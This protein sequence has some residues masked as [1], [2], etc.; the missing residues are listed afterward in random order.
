MARRGMRIGLLL[1]VVLLA[2]ACAEDA[3][4]VVDEPPEE[5]APAAEIEIAVQ[6]DEDATTTEYALRCGDDPGWSGDAPTD[7]AELPADEVCDD[8]PDRIEAAREALAAETCTQ[9]YGGPQTASVTGV[10]DGED[11]HLDV[12]RTDGCGIGAW[13]ALQPLL[14]PAENGEMVE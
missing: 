5:Q 14:G 3:I 6:P 1:I 2:A 8:L 11:V 13:E 10:M 12:H 4:P 9:E 7:R